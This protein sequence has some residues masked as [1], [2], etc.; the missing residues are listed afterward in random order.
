[1]DSSRFE[2]YARVA[3]IALL[4]AGCF[5]VIRP[6][7]AALFFAA[8]MCL[9]TWPAFRWIKERVGG[10][11]TL[12]A[13]LFALGM[14]LAIALPV[15]LAAYSLITH[16]AD[17][18]DLIRGFLDR[19]PI[20]LPG[21]LTRIPFVGGWIDDYWKVL[22]GSREEMV[23]LGKRLA[24]PA[25]NVL[26]AAGAS[27]GEGVLQILLAIFVAFFFYRDGEVVARMIR[28]G[29]ARLAGGERG[30]SVLATAQNAIKGVVY[31][32]IGTALAQ[33][34]V[35]LLGFLVAGVPAAMVL[36][37]L[38][39]VLSLV[40]MGPVIIWGGAAAWL[41]FQ[42]ETGWAVF[43]VIYG[44]LVIS[45]VDNFVKPI[46]MSRAGG[47]S[48]LLVVLGVFGGAVAF[49]FIGIFVGPALLAVAWSLVNAWLEAHLL[50]EAV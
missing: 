31:G 38:T 39:F 34:A 33:A 28:T 24:E 5:L 20:E 16:S 32:L 4:V 36:A 26:F 1:M 11:S 49:G 30:A 9:S 7:L 22:V 35:S 47:L 23:A 3:G 40:P 6:F 43:M 8:V 18:I 10:R 29:M 48:M 45:S 44:T 50:R 12:A 25:K 13:L 17:A 19:G 2:Q 37:A 42:G 14:L 41:Y 15:A 27:A 21:W 46:L